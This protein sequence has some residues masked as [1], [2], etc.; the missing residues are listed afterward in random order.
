MRRLLP[1][2]AA[3][4]ATSLGLLLSI[5]W[6][7]ARPLPDAP[8]PRRSAPPSPPAGA[9][10][11]VAAAETAP[12][13]WT[14]IASRNL[15]SPTRSEAPT[16]T[17]AATSGP[18]P[19]RPH[20]YGVVLREGAPVAYLEDPVT[21]RV[22]GYRIGDAIAGGTVQ[23]ISADR[24]VLQRPEGPV[25][26]RLHDPS[27]PRQ[28]AAPPPPAAE[29]AGAAP[30][31]ATGPRPPLVPGVAPPPALIPQPPV[32]GLGPQEAPVVPPVRRPLP[33]NLLRRVPPT[34][35][36]GSSQ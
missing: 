12:T 16:A 31:T 1:L 21:K 2:N 5:V 32:S 18:A 11:V 17:A 33:P 3:L 6:Q 28:A 26:V 35:P 4:A 23:S 22:A 10:T 27:K 7:L 30:P 14:T 20:L 34:V 15:F 29:G 9:P 24:V 36:D 13:A 19:P 8:P 25:D